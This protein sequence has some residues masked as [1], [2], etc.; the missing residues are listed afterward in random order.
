[1]FSL[2][3]PLRVLDTVIFIGEGVSLA[4]GACDYLPSSFE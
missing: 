3:F 2:F 4:V 1:M